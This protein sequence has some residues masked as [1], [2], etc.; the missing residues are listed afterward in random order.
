MTPSERRPHAV[1]PAR[2]PELLY[3]CLNYPE[4]FRLWDSQHTLADPWLI[5]A[6]DDD[7]NVY[8]TINPCPNTNPIVDVNE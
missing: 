2:D 6:L 3:R 8:R 4:A 5:G 1:F 7:G